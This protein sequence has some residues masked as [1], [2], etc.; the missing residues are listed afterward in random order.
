[1]MKDEFVILVNDSDEAVGQMEKMEAHQ[2]GLL[3]RAFSVFIFNNK[4]EMLLQRRAINKYHSGGLWSNACCSHPYP[5]EA[6]GQGAVR[7][8]R[9][10]LGFST[11][12]NKVFDFTYRAEFSNGL[13]EY[14]FDHVFT[15]EYNGVIHPDSEEVCDYC[16]KDLEDIRYSMQVHPEKFTAWLHIVFPKIEAWWKEQYEVTA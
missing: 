16:Y 13:T 9:E 1:M 15:G 3:H 11:A 6:T 2:K 14:E 7:R 8:L 4:G 12:V 5:G 10:E